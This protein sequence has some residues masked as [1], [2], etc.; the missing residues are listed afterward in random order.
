[1]GGSAIPNFEIEKARNLANT[2]G[3]G[4]EFR[5]IMACHGSADAEEYP[6]IGY[7]VVEGWTNL[8]VRM[9]VIEGRIPLSSIMERSKD[10]ALHEDFEAMLGALELA[11]EM[12][13]EAHG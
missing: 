5:P 2:V 3:R 8:R 4:D 11:E 9:A 6:C 10:I 13:E 1:M 7:L 12:K